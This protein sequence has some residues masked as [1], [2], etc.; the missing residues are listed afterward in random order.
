MRNTNLVKSLSLAV[1]VCMLPFALAAQKSPAKTATGK[2]GAANVTIKY[3]SPYVKGRTIFGELVPYDKVW[4]A[5]A[6]SATTVLTDKSL[7]VEGKSLPAGKYSFFVI[8]KASGKW[9]VIFN[10]VT[11]QW[12]AYKYEQ[13]K[14]VIRVEVQP[15]K[16][17]STESLVYEIGKGGITLKW[18]DIE[19]PISVK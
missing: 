16:T 5:G 8:P 13:S 6:D 10:S 4:R 19:L 3:S 7:K 2:T 17:A 18:A 1:M 12:G 9:T 14:D 11:A 15:K